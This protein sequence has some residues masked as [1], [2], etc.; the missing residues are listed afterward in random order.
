MPPIEP[1]QAIENEFVARYQIDEL[2][3]PWTE[4]SLKGELRWKAWASSVRL[5]QTVAPERIPEVITI[6][7]AMRDDPQHPL[8]Q[9]IG[10]STLMIWSDEPENWRVFQ[11][12]QD[13]IITDLQNPSDK[14]PTAG[15]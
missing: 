2:P 3:L 5:R 4:K 9:E 8:V 13:L 11:H 6:L 1:A 12:L 14:P 15:T 10:A 7:Q